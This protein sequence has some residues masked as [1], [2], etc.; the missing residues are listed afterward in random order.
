M[1]V[2]QLTDTTGGKAYYT[3]FGTVQRART[4]GSNGL[5]Y[6]RSGGTPTFNLHLPTQQGATT[7]ESVDL[8]RLSPPAAPGSFAVDS[9]SLTEVYS[10]STDPVCHP[11][12]S[13]GLW[14]TIA[15]QNRLEAVSRAGGSVTITQIVPVTNGFAISGRFYLLAQRSDFYADPSGALPIRGSFV[16]PLVDASKSCT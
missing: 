10:V 15:A 6:P 2:L 5:V 14:Y 1:Q 8:Y 12:R 4:V 11:P 7:E 9:I 16:A 13:W 3:I